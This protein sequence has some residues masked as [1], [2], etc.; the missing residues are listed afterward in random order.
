MSNVAINPCPE[1]AENLP[2]R[3]KKGRSV[4]ISFDINPEFPVEALHSQAY[5]AN[6]RMDL[7]LVGMD[8]DGCKST[9]CPIEAGATQSYHWTLDVDKRFPTRPFNVKMKLKNT[10]DDNFCCFMFNIKLTK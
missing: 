4:E 7:P 8:T 1:A 3:V 9:T 5:W 2:C 6:G 10:K